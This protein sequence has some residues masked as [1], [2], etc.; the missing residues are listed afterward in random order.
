MGSI[1]KKEMPVMKQAGMTLVELA[2][3]LALC[4]ILTF[5][6]GSILVSSGRVFKRHA[7]NTGA[8]EICSYTG[9]FLERKLSYS[10]CLEISYEARPRVSADQ[11][12]RFGSDGRIF[13]NGNDL[14]GDGYY[15]ERRFICEVR[16]KKENDNLE[17]PLLDLFL[18]VEDESKTVRA[19]EHI[20]TGLANLEIHGESVRYPLQKEG[21]ETDDGDII[22]SSRDH[23]L[24]IY[25]RDQEESGIIVDDTGD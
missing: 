12:F 5:A 3:G 25:F 16:R 23:D 17:K 21:S 7:E 8:S 6:A 15:A 22:Y 13:L 1:R 2:A 24:Y 11:T 20:I 9:R 18:Y 19:S 10:E 4:I 14:Y